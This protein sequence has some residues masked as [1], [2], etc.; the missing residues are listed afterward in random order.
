MNVRTYPCRLALSLLVSVVFAVAVAPAGAELQPV[1]Q[2]RWAIAERIVAPDVRAVRRQLSA[3]IE[4]GNVDWATVESVLSR[5][6]FDDTAREFLLYDILIRLRA[7]N[8]DAQ[9]ERFV[10]GLLA[11]D[12][13]TYVMHEEG[14][15]PI[16]VYPIADA[17]RGTLGA[18]QRRSA[19]RRMSDAFTRGDVRGL[20]AL[21]APGTDDY[22]GVLAALRDADALTI[23]RAGEWLTVNADG[24]NYYEARAVVALRTHDAAR[25]SDLLE[26]G[27]GPEAVRLLRAVRTHFDASQAFE[28]LED[29][30]DN[31]ELASAAVYEIDALRSAGLASRVDNY[32][33]DTLADK[34]LGATAAAVVA[35]RGDH[36]LFERVADT[37]AAPRASHDQQARAV[38]ALT[39]ADSPYARRTLEN[40]VQKGRF[41]DRDLQQEVSRW[42]QQ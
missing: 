19:E 2:E 33:I 32:L 5:P 17:A 26:I 7:A 30:T 20:R 25:V 27:R 15:L 29:A 4:E 35:R 40:A 42:L 18:W 38:L 14:P 10:T 39:L 34:T 12:S 3:A 11:Y 37:L 22:P 36:R 31:P 24:S 28:L 41:T 16:A 13:K 8:P 23:A 9:T 21:R 6:G 1:V